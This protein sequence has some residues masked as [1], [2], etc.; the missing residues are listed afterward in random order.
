MA[1]A[2]LRR[3]RGA[4]AAV[5]AESKSVET[6][7]PFL[8]YQSIDS[9]TVEQHG[10]FCLAEDIDYWFA[11]ETNS[12][13]LNRVE[14][15]AV[16]RNYP[17]IFMSEPE[18]PL[19]GSWVY[20]QTRICW[21]KPHSAVCLT[22]R[23][24]SQQT[25]PEPTSRKCKGRLGAREEAKNMTLRI[26]GRDMRARTLCKLSE[27]SAN[28]GR[29]EDR[30]FFENLAIVETKEMSYFKR[31]SIWS[32]APVGAAKAGNIALSR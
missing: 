23:V 11:S 8:F 28:V 22:L 7:R 25:M 3:R 14:F 15:S 13:P 31:V 2:P 26:E 17:I 19:W 16:A 29:E 27:L 21:S 32:E 20:A 6:Q 10:E 4:S 30:S 1:T 12:V 5:K 9:V 18:T 24:R